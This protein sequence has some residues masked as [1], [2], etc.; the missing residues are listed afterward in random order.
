VFVVVGFG[1]EVGGGAGRRVTRHDLRGRRRKPEESLRGAMHV[2]CN[3][4]E[5]S[6][7]RERRCD[8][9]TRESA[10]E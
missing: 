2:G 7:E 10:V 9:A 3:G 5:Q 8:D 6:D 4:H 1:V